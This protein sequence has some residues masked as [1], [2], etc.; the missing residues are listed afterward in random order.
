MPEGPEVKL[1]VDKLKNYENKKI[2]NIQILSG[3]FIK[4]PIDFS[5]F[6]GKSFKKIS[7]KGKFIWFEC[8]EKVIFNTLGMTGSWG[9]TL[10]NHSRICI[11]Y[12]SG[13]KIYFNDIRN[14]GTLH[15]KSNHELLKKLNSI[16]YDMLS[17]PPDIL[18][19]VRSFRKNNNKNI[20]VALMNQNIVSGI[21]NYI[22]AESLW[23]SRIYPFALI[24]DLTDKNLE[25]LYYSVLFVINESYKSQGATL[26]TY[27]TFDNESGTYTDKLY[28]YGRKTD[29]HGLP[30]IK[31]ETPDKRTTHFTERQTIGMNNSEQEKE[32]A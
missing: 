5:Y 13:E 16:G 7:C 24:K 14:F 25:I 21:G 4:K 2:K 11:E 3:R 27:Y 6:I 26:K 10:N 8:E 29:W 32:Y 20:C 19:F 22:K 1:F 12:L 28:V 15:I 30:V 9:N 18:T 17:K 23:L 31:K